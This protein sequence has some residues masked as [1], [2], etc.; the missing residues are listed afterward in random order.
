MYWKIKTTY[1]NVKLVTT[2]RRQMR[3]WVEGLICSLLGDACA[4]EVKNIVF[5]LLWMIK[6]MINYS[7]ENRTR[8]GE[9]LTFFLYFIPNGIAF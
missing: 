1:K 2:L 7:S 5:L 4:R 3:K 8:I 6:M 9:S